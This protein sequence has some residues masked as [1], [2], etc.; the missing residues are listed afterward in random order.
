MRISVASAQ[1]IVEEIGDLVRQ[2]INLMD[3]T[4]HIV[5]SNDPDRIG[6]FHPGAYEVVTQ[7]IQELYITA[8]R[9]HEDPLVR[10]GINLPIVVNGEVECVVGITGQY[11]EVIRY[12]QIVKKMAEILIRERIA[13]DAQ[14]LDQRIRTRFLEEWILGE[15]LTEPH[16]LAERGYALG[17]DIAVPRT[18]AVVSP[19]RPE[20]YADSREGQVFLEGVEQVVLSQ[21]PADCISLRNTGRLILLLPRRS[22][23]EPGKLCEALTQT[24]KERLGVQLACGLSG[25]APDLHTAYLQ[26]NRAWRYANHPDR[27]VVKFDELRMELVWDDVPREKKAEYLR[28]TFPDCSPLQMREF[29][30]LLEAWFAAEGSLHIVAQSLFIH[31][32]TIQYR[33]KRIAEITGLDVRRPSQAPALYLATQ[34]FMELEAERTSP[35]L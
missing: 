28:R 14:R 13:L 19:R 23:R 20:Q 12:G 32:N 8:E 18:C 17:I 5:A 6:N 4:G 3:Y 7:N 24:V 27:L 26:A 29:V 10:Q 15:G 21:L 11:Y 33:L 31:K 2:N 16:E 35:N 9:E 22:S 25:A 30:Q 34:F 1:Q